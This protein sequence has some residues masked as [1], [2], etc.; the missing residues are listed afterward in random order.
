MSPPVELTLNDTRY[1]YESAE[2]WRSFGL[3]IPDNQIDDVPAPS[4]GTPRAIRYNNHWKNDPIIVNGKRRWRIRFGFQWNKEGANGRLLTEEYRE[5]IRHALRWLEYETCL[6]FV[7][8]TDLEEE[9]KGIIRYFSQ[10][11]CWSYVG[12]VGKNWISI[13]DGCHTRKVIHHETL[14]TLGTGVNHQ[15][16]IIRY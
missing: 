3:E 2:Y 15:I 10:S 14:H 6:T 11:G 1:T 7:E 5:R 4:D 12:Q 8:V 9:E 16:N 13:D